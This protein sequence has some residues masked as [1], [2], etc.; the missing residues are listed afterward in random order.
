MTHVAQTQPPLGVS[1]ALSGSSPSPSGETS[2]AQGR[3]VVLIV[4]DCSEKTLVERWADEGAM[5][6]VKR[7]RERGAYGP[8]GST[9]DTLI[10]SP[11]PVIM[12]STW[13]V[14]NGFI[15]WMQWRPDRMT[16]QRCDPSWVDVKP[17]YR[18]LGPYGVV[19][20]DIPMAMDPEPFEG[21]EIASW[22]SYD[23]LC[24]LSSYPPEAIERLRK[25]YHKLPIGPELG[26][27][28][29]IRRQLKLKDSLIR[30]TEA[31]GDAARDLMREENWD[32][33]I[34]AFGATHR[35]GHNFWDHGSYRETNPPAA[36]R[37]AYDGALKAVYEAADRQLGKLLDAAP[38][39]AVVLCMAS[40]GMGPSTSRYDLMPELLSRIVDERRVTEQ[41]QEHEAASKPGLL[42]RVRGMVPVEWRSRVK[43]NLPR[44]LQD[45]LS[46]FWAGQTG[47]DWSTT[48]AFALAGDLE[49]YVRINLQ[50]REREGIVA[51]E[52]YEPLMR[53]LIEGFESWKDAE[54]GEPLVERVLRGD[55]L[56]PEVPVERRVNN[57]PDLI[58]RWSARP[59]LATQTMSSER[60][61]TLR[62]PIPDKFPDGR[63]GHHRPTGW[64]IAA[65]EGVEPGAAIENAHGIDLAPTI[66]RLMGI[67]PFE[68]M[69]GTPIPAVAS[70]AI[71]S[72]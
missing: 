54:T 22:S 13:P 57:V 53:K 32:L 5:P 1:P 8:L 71:V 29:S 7:L 26:E 40:H 20:M 25:Q 67:E 17:F 28:Q 44:G 18:R 56:W 24:D 49:G 63:S 2:A 14:E 41:E 33:F 59:V 36:S 62:W 50:G 47:Q 34:T 37:E 60:Y 72:A 39:D 30:G 12:T 6:N 42:K 38:D 68:E 21:V 51:P 43:R 66:M 69:R 45:A 4:L 3:R 70:A 48:K 64:L 9:A 11:W 19:A 16:E 10:A 65:G 15:C 58:V 31:A 61:G 35:A 23:K 55:E 52:D 46:K 27:L